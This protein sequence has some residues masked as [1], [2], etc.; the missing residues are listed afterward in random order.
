VRALVAAS[1]LL[2]ACDDA[3]VLEVRPDP[4]VPTDQVTLFVG[5]KSCDDCPG[6]AP[7]PDKSATKT[8]ILPGRVFFREDS[9]MP[10]VVRTAKVDGGVAR[11]RI[12]PSE[13]SD[14]LTIAV[15]VDA[16]EQSAAIVQDLP[17]DTAG[18]YRVQLTKASTMLGG[19]QASAGASTS[20]AIWPQPNG[21]L[22]CIGFERWDGGELQG[23]RVFIVPAT[24]PDCDSVAAQDECAPFGF[25]A[26]GVPPLEEVSCTRITP[27]T[28]DGMA[29]MLGGPSCNEALATRDACTPSEYCVPSMYCDPQNAKCGDGDVVACLFDT[30]SPPAGKLKCTIPFMPASPANVVCKTSGTFTIPVTAGTSCVPVDKMLL[31]RPMPPP[32]ELDHTV[33]Y[34]SV[35]AGTVMHSM[36]LELRHENACTYRIDIEGDFAINE[37][38]SE[39]AFAELVLQRNAGPLRKMLV[40]IE[41]VQSADCTKAPSCALVL[42]QADSI[43]ACMSR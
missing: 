26:Q 13:L 35:S 43:S 34:R 30:P 25:L 15:A 1:L 4:S 32:L 5:L 42:D 16:N 36:K 12:E 28:M 11:F 24:D 23:E 10:V 22:S 3:V 20:V 29:C 31:S 33:E 40:P 27:V 38:P 37:T 2:A 6:I 14:H 18:I 21:N 9:N 17:L 19:P 41:I 7:R 8:E 39:V